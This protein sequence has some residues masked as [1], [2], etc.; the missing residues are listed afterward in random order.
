MKN[1]FLLIL[2]L[3]FSAAVFAQSRSVIVIKS[4]SAQDDSQVIQINERGEETVITPGA[5]A[6]EKPAPKPAEETVR[7]EKG[8]A[9]DSKP[10]EVEKKKPNPCSQPK[11]ASKPS[12]PKSKTI[13]QKQKK[14]RFHRLT[15]Q[16]GGAANYAWGSVFEQPEVFNKSLL[17]VNSTGFIGIRMGMREQ[18]GKANLFGIWGRNGLMTQNA[19]NTILN[20]QGISLSNPNKVKDKFF[21]EWEV[22]FVYREWFR[23]SAGMGYMQVDLDNEFIRDLPGNTGSSDQIVLSPFPTDEDIVVNTMSDNYDLFYYSTTAGFS[24]RMGRNVRWVSNAT[25][26]FGQDFNKMMF[27]PSTGLVWNLNFLRI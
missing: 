15:L 27:R 25:I 18:N 17:G 12:P 3:T 14:E 10:V 8:P 20:Y 13:P 26:L 9:Y 16:V 6:E 2:L 22:G 5:P 1:T 19:A 11:T 7:V 4:K 21:S 23:L 24:F